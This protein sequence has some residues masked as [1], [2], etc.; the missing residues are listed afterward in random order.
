MSN[1]YIKVNL[2]S[3][4]IDRYV[5]RRS[6]I[7]AIRWGLPRFTGRFLDVGCGRAPYMNFIKVKSQISEYVTLDIE[8][9]DY[10]HFKPDYIWDGKH[11]P[12]NADSF[13]TVM[14]TEVLEHAPDP[15]SLLTSIHSILQKEGVFF[16]TTPFFWNLHE[17]PYDQFRYTPFA[18][19]RLLKEAGFDHIEIYASGGW[20]S[21]FAQ[22][23]GLWLR[24]SNLN[25]TIRK[26]LSYFS[27]YL[28]R[29]LVKIDKPIKDFNHP[30]M[31]T[32][33]YGIAKK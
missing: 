19:E 10:S 30:H 17:I 26:S 9:A 8:G 23:L 22:M 7:N 33:I 20:H 29:Y 15:L 11:M 21:S 12:F 28:I 25:E 3:E 16:F 1:P 14:A 18:L 24:R 5:A 2:T 27:K 32:T 13:N 6:I 31:L 4:Y